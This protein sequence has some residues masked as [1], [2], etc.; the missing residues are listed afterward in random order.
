MPAIAWPSR[1]RYQGCCGALGSFCA[2]SEPGAT[3][4]EGGVAGQASPGPLLPAERSAGNFAGGGTRFRSAPRS[5]QRPRL[6]RRRGPSTVGSVRGSRQPLPPPGSG[7]GFP[8]PAWSTA[9]QPGSLGP[10]SLRRGKFFFFWGG[11]GAAAAASRVGEEARPGLA[12]RPPLPPLP[13]PTEIWEP[14]HFLS[15]A[16]M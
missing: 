8:K 3:T 14:R 16:P 2:L 11:G 12:A 9:R 13:C 15:P 4:G 1:Q 10:E 7:T 6:T 5:A